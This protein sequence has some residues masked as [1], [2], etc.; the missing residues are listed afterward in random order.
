MIA[1]GDYKHI[2]TGP[3]AKAEEAG[4]LPGKVKHET[5]REKLLLGT[6]PITPT[7]REG[8]L[9][10]LRLSGVTFPEQSG[11]S[12]DQSLHG[13]EAKTAVQMATETQEGED[14]ELRLSLG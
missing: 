2:N 12:E 3:G 9:Y 4:G 7:G 10:L 14:T 11:M 5:Q 6:A 1:F 8:S 13:Q